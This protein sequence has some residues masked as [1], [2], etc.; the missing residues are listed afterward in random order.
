MCCSFFPPFLL[1]RD[2][3][4]VS[5]EWGEAWSGGLKAVT[6]GLAQDWLSQVCMGSACEA[7]FLSNPF[8]WIDSF[9][10]G[11]R[12]LAASCCTLLFCLVVCSSAWLLGFSLDICGFINHRFQSGKNKSHFCLKKKITKNRE[13]KGF[14]S[15][16]SS[17]RNASLWFVC[18]SLVRTARRWRRRPSASRTWSSSSWSVRAGRT[19]RR[20]PTPSSCWGRSQ[21]TRGAP[22][23][24]R[25]VEVEVEVE[26]FS[27]AGRRSG[28]YCVVA[29]CVASLN[30]ILK[31]RHYQSEV[32][33][34]LP[35]QLFIFICTPI[36]VGTYLR[37]HVYER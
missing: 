3:S 31:C 16:S 1:L 14:E 10:M 9:R 34:H 36:T 5:G 6:E 25:W 8:F 22:S 37:H 32:W 29:S 12:L 4:K 28:F 21:T 35:M 19:R 15:N 26:R 7:R 13:K 11:K 24:A 20:R 17:H 2:T 18:V 23:P 27:P 30:G 33:T